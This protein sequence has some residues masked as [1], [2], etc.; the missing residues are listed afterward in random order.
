M[1][2]RGFLVASAL[3]ALAAACGYDYEPLDPAPEVR[4]FMQPDEMTMAAGDS[5]RL[6]AWYGGSRVEVESRDTAIALLRITN[7][8]GTATGQLWVHA[9]VPGITW[10]VVSVV[11]APGRSDS[12]R[13]QVTP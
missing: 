11:E 7:P 4:I 9:G 1:R 8:P 12:L 3:L 6:R 5:L 13:V 2:L 10:V